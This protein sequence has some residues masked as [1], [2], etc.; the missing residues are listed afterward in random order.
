[1]DLRDLKALQL[2]YPECSEGTATSVR[3]WGSLKTVE[4]IGRVYITC[5]EFRDSIY[6]QPADKQYQPITRLLCMYSGGSVLRASMEDLEVHY[7]K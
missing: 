1:M 6:G 7:E 3:A 5:L 4:T 2:L